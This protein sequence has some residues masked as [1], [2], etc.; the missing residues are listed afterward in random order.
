MAILQTLREKAGPLVAGV[1]GVSLLL[2]VVSD[3]FGNNTSQRRKADKYYQ[4]ALI[5]GESV[6][7][8]DFEARVQDLVDIYKMSGTNEVNE[9][10]MLSLREQVWQQML[11]EKLMD[12]TYKKTGLG[13]SPDEVEMLVFGDD[14][15]PIVRQLFTDPSTGAFNQSFLVNFLKATETDEATKRYWLFF[16][17]Q[18]IS[19]RLNT[20]LVNLMSKGL[21]VT[22]KQSE[23]EA[24][25]T[26][27]TVNF[28]FI[29][30]NYAT[31]SDSA[32]NVTPDEIKKYYDG[33]KDNFKRTAQRDME[34]MVFDITPSESDMKETETWAT[35]EKENFAAATDI[36]QYINLTADNRHTGFYKTLSELPESVRGLAESGDRSAVY[37][38]YLEAGAY[39]IARI[40]DIAE[41]PDSVRAAHI[42]LSPNAG[43][44]I[45]QAKM[46]ADSLINLVRSG[47]DFEVLAMANSEDQ[48]SAQVGGDLGWFSEGMMIVPF[49]NACFSGKKGD[50]V[51]VETTFGL[52]IIKI[53]DQSPRVKKYDIGVVDRQVI[54]SSATTQRL[55]AEASQFAGTNDTYEK[56]NKAVAEGNLNKK[57]ALNITPDQK[58]LPGLEQAR[59][60]VMALFQNSKQ[61]AI[62]LDNGSQAVFELP[63]MYVVAYCTRVQEEGTA[64]LEDVTSDIRFILAKKKKVEM[65]STEMKKLAAEGKTLYDIAAQYKSTVQDASG[66]N[67]RSFSVPG[68]GIEPGL[69]AAASTSETGVLSKPVEGNNGVY[70]FVVNSAS[71]TAAEDMAVVRERLNSN[72][73]IRASYEA[74]QAIR[75]K[76]KVEDLRYKFY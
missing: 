24:G 7:Y 64:P 52:H 70:M 39:K 2:F 63:N 76:K 55:Y 73:Q 71:P 34:Y 44:S 15:H 67:F 54:P 9:E 17:D 32:V 12:N 40:V 72:Y 4:L 35:N 56:F 61:G 50:L 18:I 6:S 10:M 69:I 3:F 26:G 22:G 8:Q 43:R 41:R 5:D 48:G 42:L 57:L 49:N 25:L 47:I 37:G 19:D 31:V 59:G 58:E 20:K 16:E 36:V 53:I 38:P 46:E 68:A 62:V 11:S 1:I 30:R 29:A 65:I 21:Y 74:Y 33:H 27:N 13:V 75:D 60:L 51:T 66:I 28:S 45:A 14:P 23:Y